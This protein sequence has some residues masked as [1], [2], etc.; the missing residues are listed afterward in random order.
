MLFVLVYKCNHIIQQC[1]ENVFC[2]LYIKIFHILLL[3]NIFLGEVVRG[4]VT[5]FNV[6]DIHMVNW[7]MF[8][9]DYKMHIPYCHKGC[10]AT[11]VSPRV[12]IG[13]DICIGT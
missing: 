11:R 12:K 1:L 8:L 10:R 6:Y 2:T 5:V 7:L 3:E 13:N 4:I 9:I